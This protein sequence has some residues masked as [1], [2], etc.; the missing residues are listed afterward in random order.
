MPSSDAV[1][2]PRKAS[3]SS[4]SW[5]RRSPIADYLAGAALI[6]DF[7][8]AVSGSR[9]AGAAKTDEEMLAQDWQAVGGDLQRAM[10]RHP[11]DGS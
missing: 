9:A 3:K 4:T 11:L 2:R 10:S 5:W 7:S 8:G 6:F 1:V